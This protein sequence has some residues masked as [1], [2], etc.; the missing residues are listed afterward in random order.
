MATTSTRIRDELEQVPPV[1]R[2]GFMSEL[3]PRRLVILSMLLLFVE[4]ALIRW[5][6]AE[7]VHLANITNFVLLASFLGIGVGFL[8]AGI[9]R[10]LFR[11][12]PVSLALLVAFVLLF[13][14]R[15]VTLRGPHEFQGLSGHSPLAQPVS[16]TVIFVLVVLVMLGIGQAMARMFAQFRPLDAYRLD[17]IG[18]VG[19]IVLFS[20]LSFAGLPPIAW[21]AVVAAG[22][23]LLLGVHQRWWQWVALAA[24]VVMLLLESLSTV[25]IWSPYYKITTRQV[26]TSAPGGRYHGLGVSANN[27]PYQTVFPISTLHRIESFYFFP[28][29]HVTRSSLSNELVIGAGT[30]N[31]VGAALAEGARHVDAVEIDPDLVQLGREDNPEHAYQSPRV[32]VHINDG[33]AFLQ[34]TGQRYSL[35]LYALPDSLTA[36]TG[37]SAPVGLENYLLTT[38]AIQVAR[39]HL[40]PG[41][42]FAMYNYY[43]PFLLDRYATALGEVFGTRPCVE[44]GDSLNGRRQ[45][46]LTVA[47]DGRTPDCA[48]FWNGHQ[49]GPVS[50]DR[51][52]PYLPTPSIPNL[53]LWVAGLVLAGSLV[54]VR[55][56]GGP[57]KKMA[58]FVDLFWMGAAFLLLESKNIVQFALL[59]GTTWYVNSLVFAGILLSI[60]AAVETA[61]HVKLPRPVLLYGGL[62]VA[63]A[64]SFVVPQASLLDLP[65]LFRF[66]AASALAFAPVF[67]ANLVFAQRFKDVGSSTTA[68]GANLLGAIVGGVL[69]YLSLV[70]GFRFLLVVVAV[71][72]GLAVLFGRRHLVLR[73]VGK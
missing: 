13:P 72:Y 33:R 48:S 3:S 32:S 38:Q 47:R 26:T 23:V 49:V 29:R 43:Q 35:I 16:L 15:L 59:F 60:Y 28:Y 8:L 12:T 1:D 62:L 58:R 56:A 66:V 61:R 27:I 45:A 44:L 40:A 11:F 52:F 63:L 14:V 7:N 22:F 24:V 57:I 2:R 4:L 34:D 39:D 6:A 37:Q 55:A 67:L 71:M 54:L 73:P 21:G 36:L 42:T 51:P 31:D 41:G 50:D 10:D 30:G 53:Y 5:T 25:D 68:F 65:V 19:G 20:V 46:V 70:T 9:R 18:S 17:I 69:E 64:V